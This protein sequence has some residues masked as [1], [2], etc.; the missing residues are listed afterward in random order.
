MPD[1]KLTAIN[2]NALPWEER[3]NEKIGR[4]LYRK[5]LIVDP[6]TGMEVRQTDLRMVGGQ[7]VGEPHTD[8]VALSGAKEEFTGS[9][10]PV[11]I[12]QA[13]NI[14]RSPAIPRYFQ[15]TL[16]ERAD[17]AVAAPGSLG[18]NKKVSPLGKIVPHILHLF[19][20]QPGEPAGGRRRKVA[21]G[22]EHPAE[23]GNGEKRRFDNGL[24]AVEEGYQQQRIKIG[25]MIA[26]NHGRP[27]FCNILIKNPL[28]AGGDPLQEREKP[29]V[30]GP[31][32]SLEAILRPGGKESGRKIKGGEEQEKAKGEISPAD[33]GDGDIEDPVRTSAPH[34]PM[35]LPRDHFS[36]ADR[37]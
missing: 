13:E 25:E 24:C 21:G 2:S 11:G 29:L 8:E 36:P 30:K 33:A 32:Q 12:P 5:N 23:D 10:Q 4:S 3:P 9:E 31:V 17:A 15:G 27:D 26:D 14:D 34:R 35:R 1:V 20:H 7:A 19:Q 37:Y 16:I 22:A 28:L 6:D 18:K